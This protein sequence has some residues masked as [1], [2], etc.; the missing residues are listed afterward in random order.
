MI[1]SFE[2]YKAIYKDHNY[3]VNRIKKSEQNITELITKH[4]NKLTQENIRVNIELNTLQQVNEK[5]KNRLKKYEKD[6]IPINT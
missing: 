6:G 5:L 4:L 3:S 1:M 2:E